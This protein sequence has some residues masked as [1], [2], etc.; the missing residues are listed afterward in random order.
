MQASE[1]HCKFTSMTLPGT[2]SEGQVK[3]AFEDAQYRDR[4]EHPVR[5]LRGLRHGVG[6][7]ISQRQRQPVRGPILRRDLL[8]D[9]LQEVGTGAGR[10]LPRR[11]DCEL[12]NWSVVRG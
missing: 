3:D 10:A 4:E 9:A 2:L 12:D 11:P 7:A 5:L 8:A 1:K 6:A